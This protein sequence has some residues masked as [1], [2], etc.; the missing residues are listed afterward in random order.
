MEMPRY[1]VT[2]VHDCG[3]GEVEVEAAS[4]KD[5][6]RAAKQSAGVR[7]TYAHARKIGDK[8]ARRG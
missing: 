5:A 1:L 3:C 8:H 6:I 7:V 2:T 4:P